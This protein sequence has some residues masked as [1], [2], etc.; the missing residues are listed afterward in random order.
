MSQLSTSASFPPAASNDAE[1]GGSIQHRTYQLLREMI[2]SGRIAPGE[3]LLEAQVARSFSI[4]RSPA[5][6]ALAMLCSDRLLVENEGRGYR[7]AG[8]ARGECAGRVATLE[9]VDL[10]GEPQWQRM[11][12]AVERELCT[13]VLF[14]TV[15]ITEE[16]LAEHFD[17]SRTVARDVMARMHSV[18][19][20]SKDKGGHWIAERVTQERIG[21][22]FEMRCLVE[23]VALVQAASRVP[24]AWLEGVRDKLAAQI[25]SGQRE[26]KDMDEAETDLHIRLLSY[27]PNK[28]MTVALARTHVLFVPTRYLADPYLQIPGQLIND[29]FTE[30]LQIIDALLSD[31]PQRTASLLYEHINE[32]RK[33]WM[34]RFD[35]VS[36]MKQ[37]PLP[38]YLSKVKDE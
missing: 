7:V 18:G 17:V 16:R 19:M 23:P 20:L 28:E 29:A 12:A 24:R 34:L 1:V 25:A 6:I 14:G 9:Q 26:A 32:A 21:H 38:S 11:Y 30:H 15:R 22:L 3:K 35:I 10:T 2:E 33:R 5:R 27:C 36:R 31:D 37:P 13:R 8:K 4:G